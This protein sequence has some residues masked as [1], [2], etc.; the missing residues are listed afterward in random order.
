MFSYKKTPTTCTVGCALLKKQRNNITERR[1]NQK[2]YSLE[3]IEFQDNDQLTNLESLII[4]H[5]PEVVYFPQ[6]PSSTKDG[7]LK[8]IAK[9]V[10]DVLEN[11]RVLGN[12][13]PMNLFTEGDV[14]NKLKHCLGVQNLLQFSQEV[15]SCILV[16]D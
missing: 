1:E 2:R 12:P 8:K 5:T 10:N 3:I 9:A 7:L 6:N 16:L 4:R 13:L 14:E 11:T 15:H